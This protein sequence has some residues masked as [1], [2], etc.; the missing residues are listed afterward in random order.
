MNSLHR[1]EQRQRLTEIRPR[2]V[3]AALDKRHAI[4]S[5]IQRAIAVVG[6]T[7]KEAAA[8]IWPERDIDAAQAQL[9]KW[10]RATERPHFDVL[11]G[12]PELEW[13]LIESLALIGRACEVNTE[14]RRRIA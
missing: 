5:A 2:M 3:Q 8:H 13:P 14:I 6:W 12:V 9:S 7:D 10:L 11:F 4:A 1:D